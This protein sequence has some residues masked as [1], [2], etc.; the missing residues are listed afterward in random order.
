VAHRE[1]L[2]EVWERLSLSWRMLTLGPLGGGDGE[3]RSARH[4]CLESSTA[5]PLEGRAE[6]PGA[7]TINA[8]KGRW[9]ASWEAV[10]E[11]RE[12]PSGSVYNQC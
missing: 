2:L 3:Y 8:K 7:P 12:N 6:G 9:W 4:Q 1:A 10:T 5:G 11:V